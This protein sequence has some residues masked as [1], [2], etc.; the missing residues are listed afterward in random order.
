MPCPPP[1]IASRS[2]LYLRRTSPLHREEGVRVRG[3]FPLPPSVSCPPMP[4]NLGVCGCVCVEVDLPNPTPRT[5]SR[6]RAPAKSGDLSALRGANWAILSQNQGKNA[7]IFLL[8]PKA[9]AQPRSIY[10]QPKLGATFRVFFSVK[11]LKSSIF[12]SHLR[13]SRVHNI[14]CF[15][16]TCAKTQPFVPQS[17][18]IIA[19]QTHA[20]VLFTSVTPVNHTRW[21]SST[22]NNTEG[23]G[24]GQAIHLFT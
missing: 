18:I 12:H 8:A 21:R 20:K 10:N 5:N 4:A 19:S 11:N 22:A 3:E 17:S 15:G 1:P 9:L 16:G 23:G 6:G 24:G 2:N 13:R 14:N 7:Q